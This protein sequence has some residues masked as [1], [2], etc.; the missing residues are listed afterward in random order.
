METNAGI[1]A[2]VIGTG[3]GALSIAAALSKESLKVEVLSEKD[4]NEPWPYT[5][6][7]W[8]EEVDQIGI[9]NL[10]EHR[11]KNTVSFFG[12]GA[13]E[14]F[15]IN[16]T[17]TKHERDYGLFDKLK[18]QKYLIKECES[19]FVKWHRGI[20]SDIDINHS[21]STVTTTEGEKLSARLVIDATGYKPIFLNVPDQGPIAVQTCYGVVA[22]FSAPPVEEGQFVL[23]D[24]RC[25]HL[26][27]DEKE[28]PPTF[29][30]AMD[31]GKGKFFLEETSL[32]LSPPL[33]LEVLKR[34]LHKRLKSRGIKITSLE[35]EEL[36]LF[37]PMNIPIPD[38][39]QPILGFGGAAGMVHPASGYLVGSLLR[40]APEVAK[41]VAKA[42]D[43]KSSSPA[44][45]ASKG[46]NALWT[47]ELRR[48]KALYTF[49]LEK[50][51]RFKEPQL[52]DFFIEFF[53]LP[54]KEWYGFLTNTLSV[55]ELINAMWKMYKKAPLSVKWGLMEMQGRE[56]KLLW[57]FIKP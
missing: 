33:E 19:A 46:W 57:K 23:M 40:R 5:Y 6:G 35:H 34:R 11:W 27:E 32:G 7:I 52:R 29:L 48:K 37:L 51:M 49:G 1:D 16:N 21:I 20:A 54:D 47:P 17:P 15:S 18:L 50:L 38:L 39:K 25:D 45:I 44:E 8:G 22:E 26:T 36:G 30:Y 53:A 10:L 13:K 28:E 14:K 31:F 2:L 24:Y 42:M 55:Q 41:A 9:S 43:D 12:S 56:L 3:P 4:P